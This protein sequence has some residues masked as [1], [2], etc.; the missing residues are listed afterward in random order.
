MRALHWNLIPSGSPSPGCWQRLR[1][2][3]SKN[4]QRTKQRFTQLFVVRTKTSDYL[5]KRCILVPGFSSFEFGWFKW[6]SNSEEIRFFFMP[7][8]KLF[9]T[10]CRDC[11]QSKVIFLI[12]WSLLSLYNP[13]KYCNEMIQMHSS[14]AFIAFT[15]LCKDPLTSDWTFTVPIFKCLAGNLLYATVFYNEESTFTFITVF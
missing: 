8:K 3:I 14:L 10:W 2:L 11:I 9:L 13:V 5:V 1:N 6:T 12:N 7:L 4:S 15:F